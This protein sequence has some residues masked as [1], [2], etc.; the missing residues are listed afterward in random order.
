MREGMEEL[1]LLDAVVWI[2]LIRVYD[3]DDSYPAMLQY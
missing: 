2:V 1:V 3:S